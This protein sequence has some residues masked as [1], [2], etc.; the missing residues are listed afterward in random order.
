M[1]RDIRIDALRALAILLI[2]FA[3]TRPPQWLYELR[4]F[5]VVLMTFILGASY[6]LSRER[7]K[8][9][10]YLLYLKERFMRLIVPAWTFLSLF[11]LLLFIFV[12]T[13]KQTFPFSFKSVLTS[14]SL[15]WGI[16]YIWIIRVFFIIAILSPLLYWLAKKAAHPL[17]KLGIIGICLLLQV[18]LDTL[19]TKLTGISHTLFEQY[20]AISFGYALA[21][22]IGIWAVR[23]RKKENLILFSFFLALFFILAIYQNLPSIEGNKYPP[24]AYF[25]SYGLAG[26][27]LLFWLTSNRTVERFL[28]KV[29]GIDWL[30]QHSLELYYWHLFPIMYFNLFI[31]HDPWFLRFFV[32]FPVAF[33]LTFFQNRYIPHLFQAQKKK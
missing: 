21:A 22:L 16:G 29:P 2:M 30:S 31:D 27:L 20:I 17:K 32:A 14:Y 26:S 1:K 5:D 18:G 13:T 19:T 8:A 4:D 25:I 24:T 10:P 33:A 11:F 12:I 7:K 3:H 9:K 23:Q 28:Q 15:T 6:C